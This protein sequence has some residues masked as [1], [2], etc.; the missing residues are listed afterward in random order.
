VKQQAFYRDTAIGHFYLNPDGLLVYWSWGCR[1]RTNKAI[2]HA[3]NKILS[4][5]VANMRVAKKMSA[6]A[7]GILTDFPST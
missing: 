5:M 4:R 7:Y 1:R 2:N 3:K 6:G